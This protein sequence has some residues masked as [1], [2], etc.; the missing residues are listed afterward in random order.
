MAFTSRTTTLPTRSRPASVVTA[1]IKYRRRRSSSG[2]AQQQRTR[3][4]QSIRRDNIVCKT[5]MNDVQ[6]LFT[7]RPRTNARRQPV[8]SFRRSVLFPGRGCFIFVRV[9]PITGRPFFTRNAPGPLRRPF[10][11]TFSCLRSYFWSARTTNPPEARQR[12]D[13]TCIRRVARACSDVTN[14]NG[15]GER[16]AVGTQ[17]R[18]QN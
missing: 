11:R 7:R 8:F 5:Y 12:G 14:A 16:Y 6:S 18:I 1:A 3:G 15:S 17:A 13:T 9:P 10:R 2:N 4:G